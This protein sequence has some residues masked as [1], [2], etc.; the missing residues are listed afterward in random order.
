MH[1]V[2]ILQTSDTAICD[3][4]NLAKM[5]SDKS[6]SV[7]DGTLLDNTNGTRDQRMSQIVELTALHTRMAGGESCL[8]ALA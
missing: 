1:P 3:L 8:S 5:D 6:P 4:E 7:V 2:Q